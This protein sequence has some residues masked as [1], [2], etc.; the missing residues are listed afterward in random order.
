M[1]RLAVTA[2]LFVSFLAN[3]FAQAVPEGFELTPKKLAYKIREK[4]GSDRAPKLGEYLT[5]HL[6]YRTSTDS[7]L[8]DSR[9]LKKPYQIR[10]TDPA[11][12]KDVMEGYSIL[13]EGDSATFAVPA[14][15]FFPRELN[16]N[17]PKDIP[18]GSNIFFEVRL[19]KIQSQEEIAAEIKAKADANRLKEKKRFDDYLAL[20]DWKADPRPSGLVCHQIEAGSGTQA[21]GGHYVSVHYIGQLLDGREFDNS[22]KRGRPIEFEL[23][24]G[25][26]IKGWEEAIEGMQVGEKAILVVPSSLGYGASGAPGSIIGPFEPLVFQMELVK[27]R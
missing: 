17:R 25:Q 11:Y 26:M 9:N 20:Q 10:L 15:V 23:E 5:L 8:F 4:S 18:N 13:N 21:R 24:K 3:G 1:L 16:I 22:Y 19:L 7:V 14:N 27:I 6:L 12:K 2:L